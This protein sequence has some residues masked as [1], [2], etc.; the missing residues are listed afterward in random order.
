MWIGAASERNRYYAQYDTVLINGGSLFDGEEGL[1]LS[2]V[3]K[4][5]DAN[6]YW[7]DAGQDGVYN[8]QTDVLLYL[9]GVHALNEGQAGDEFSPVFYSD[10]DGSG[11]FSQDGLLAYYRFDDGGSSVEDFSRKAKNGLL[12]TVTES[13]RFGDH[14]YALMTNHFQWV[15]SGAA[16][17]YGAVAYGADDSDH[18]GMP[19]A[20]EATYNLNPYDNGTGMETATG[21][22]NGPFGP[23]GDPDK[24]GLNNLYEFQAGTNPRAADSNGDGEQDGQEDYDGDN[25]VNRTEQS[26]LSRPDMVDTDDDGLPDNVEQGNRTSPVNPLDPPVSRAMTFGG[27]ATDY[28]NVPQTTAMSLQNW[29][30]EAAVQPADA[31]GGVLLRRVVQQVSAGVEAMNYI[32]ALEP[33]GVGGLRL[34][35]GYV[36]LDGSN[37]LVR[38]GSV[39]VGTSVWTYVAASYNSENAT[40]A[41][42]V[43]GAQVLSTNNLFKSPPQS[44]KGGENFIRIGESY[45]GNL[46]EV[47]LWN[48]ARPE[49]EMQDA[50]GKIQAPDADGLVAYFPF[51]DG[52][53]TTNYF[54][55]GAYH[56]PQ[57]PQNWCFSDDW[58]DQWRH[59]G[60]I[61]GN[62]TFL[63]GGAGIL[64]ALVYMELAAA[65]G[66]PVSY[67]EADRASA[68]WMVDDVSQTWQESG[69]SASLDVGEEYLIRFRSINGWT[70]PD[71]VSLSITNS[72][73]IYL[74]NYYNY[75]GSST[76]GVYCVS[77]QIINE[78]AWTNALPPPGD[79]TMMGQLVIGVWSE[80]SD[81]IGRPFTNQ[82]R[83]SRALCSS[84][85]A[86]VDYGIGPL[87]PLTYPNS[88]QLLA[89]I[90]GDADL[91]YDLGEPCSVI[92]TVGYS[93]LPSGVLGFNL[94][95][96]D[97]SDDDDLPDW[98]EIHCFGDLDETK[99]GDYDK[100]ELTNYE[101][102]T[103]PFTTPAI[104][105]LNAGA[106]DSDGDGMDDKWEYDR[107]NVGFG[108]NPSIPDAWGDPDGDGLFNIQEYN[109]VD[110]EPRLKQNPAAPTGVALEDEYS[111]DDLN[112]S[113]YDTDGD[114]LVDAFEYA[115]Y[116]EA[117]G[118]NPNDASVNIAADP[119]ADGMT[120][121]REQCLLTEF[122]EGGSNDVWSA[123]TNALPKVDAYGV[124]AFVP[125][126]QFVVS[127]V[128]DVAQV[129]E[130]LQLLE[131]WTSPILADSDGDLLPD[132]WEV[133][134]NLNPKVLLGND[135]YWGDPDHDSRINY[136]EFLGQDAA[137]ST[138]KPFI[139]GTGDETNPYQYNWVPASTGPGTGMARPAVPSS[140]WNSNT[141]ASAFATLGGGRPTTS[142]GAHAGADTDD[143]GYADD[144]EIQQEYYN[145]GTVGS[146]PVH[147]MSPFIRRAALITDAAGIALPDPEGA[148]NGYS[149]LLHAAN[150]TIECYVK[151][152]T[153]DATGWLINNPGPNSI[154]EV[155]Y[156]L[157]LTNNVPVLSFETIGGTRY[158]VSGP[159]I[160]TNRWIYLAGVW[161]DADN[162][163]A[164]YVDG[165]FVQDQRIYES[166]RSAYLYGSCTNVTLGASA[167]GSFVNNLMMDE[168]RIWTEFRTAEEIETYRRI[169]VP[170]TNAGLKAYFRFDDGGL[171]AEDFAA[172]AKNTALGADQTNFYYGDMG[173]ALSGG[174]TMTTNDPADVRGVDWRGADDSDGDGMPDAW[175]MI[176]HLDPFSAEGVNGADGD[177]DVDTLRNLYEY[178]SDTNPR[179]ADT[180]GNAVLD[181]SEDRDGDTVVNGIEQQLGSRPDLI[182][183]D[184]DGLTDNE[185]RNQGTNPADPVDP[186]VGRAIRLGGAAADYLDVPAS[187]SQRLLQWTLEAWVNPDSASGGSGRLIR[188]AVQSLGGGVYAENYVMGLRTNSSGVLQLYAG[189]TLLNGNSY[190]VYGGV[191]TNG[192]WTHVAAAYDSATASLELYMNGV[193]VAASNA[194]NNAPPVNGRGGDTFVRIGEDVQGQVDDVRVWSSVRTTNQIS[195]NMNTVIDGA[196]AGL[197]NYFRMDDAQAVTNAAPFGPYHQPYGAQDFTVT[198]DW[199]NQWSHAAMLHGNAAFV[200][201]DSGGPVVIPP[202]VQVNLLPLEAV[203]D[204]AQWSLNGGAWQDST[205]IV[206]ATAGV[207]AVTF[208]TVDGWVTP[209]TLSLTL[210]NSMTLSTNVYYTQG[211]GIQ[212]DLDPAEAVS[213]GATWRVEGGAWQASEAV[214]SNLA[215]GSYYVEY[216]ALANWAAPAAEYV[217]VLEGD[218]TQLVRIY[219]PER[220]AIRVTISPAEAVAAGAHWRVNSN[221]WQNSGATVNLTS[222]TYR[223]DYQVLSGWLTPQSVTVAVSNNVTTVL[224]PVYYRYD[225]I[226]AF[227]YGEGQFNRPGGVTVDRSG[228]LYVSDTGNNRI[229]IRRFDGSWAVLGGPGNGLGRFNQPYGLTVGGDGRLYVADANN[230]RVQCYNTF[231]QSWQAWGGV[232]GSAQG[233]FNSPFDVELDTLGNL[234]VAD[235]SNH[236]IQKKNTANDWSTLISSGFAVGEVRF[237]RGLASDGAGHF[238]VSDYLTA[239]GPTSRVQRIA[240]DGA[241]AS[242][243]ASSSTSNGLIGKVAGLAVGS[244]NTLLMADNLNSRLW[245]VLLSSGTCSETLGEDVL[246]G[247]EDVAVDYQGNIYVADTKNHRILLLYVGQSSSA[248]VQ[249]NQYHYRN[250]FDGDGRA[251]PTV[252]W[253]GGG[254][255]YM[256][257]SGGGTA[258]HMLGGLVDIPACGDYDGDGKT[259]QAV[260]RSR[261]GLWLI[262]LSSGGTLSRSW[263]WAETIPVPADFDGDGRTDVCVYWPAGGM[264]Y[265]LFSQGGS[266][267]RA[268]GWAATRPI[269]GDFDGD[270]RADMTVY[271]SEQGKWY[272]YSSS[273]MSLVM[274]NWGWS[275][276][277]PVPGD[278]DAD[279][280]ADVAVYHP[281]T[282]AWMAYLSSSAAMYSRSWGWSEAVPVP[283][284]YDGDGKTDVAV[285]YGVT[286]AWLI[287]NSGSASMTELNWGWSETNPIY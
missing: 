40:L 8:Q 86:S 153:L 181:I 169:L 239:N 207:N 282:G 99:D 53:A 193:R 231:D 272:I 225:I 36:Q 72:E 167:D 119:D 201:V 258:T 18:D 31:N 110:G 199:L 15:T 247:P 48:Y 101:E 120:T 107:F 21:L 1:L 227:G 108:L 249:T 202:T 111:E 278:Y 235:R 186:V 212:I 3:L 204:G 238:Y 198:K 197:V 149:P 226:G 208:R 84:L 152:S 96:V 105:F 188:R 79:G 242:V 13:Y 206:T 102:Y 200:K 41:I 76:T 132:G 47:R 277:L 287:W 174:F 250:D 103:T 20:W 151:V 221:A 269:A 115:W 17:V 182:D 248:T 37:Y 185:E 283:G 56:Q 45:A 7:I 109:G 146:S 14:G 179:A 11:D 124:Y 42:Y 80:T 51:N 170:Q 93:E 266:A 213:A 57:G 117:A 150:W 43:N 138:N 262:H 134:Y 126:L 254:T 58:N 223:V 50:L 5:T 244:S 230:H 176:N 25:L 285:Y 243:V 155:T 171:T 22:Q 148:A 54:P 190:Y 273:A 237:P 264:W 203:T 192:A 271:W 92:K 252:Y 10:K 60:V 69:D 30:M 26:L 232:M 205:V 121:Y 6:N 131:E 261:D 106:F 55:F 125:P 64:P 59:A 113:H 211:G 276:V 135:G 82:T 209:Q 166:G 144:V 156:R 145:S 33:D 97:D 257:Y 286:G 114:G 158:E 263:G 214:V 118:I 172:K 180:D 63:E 284:D 9:D 191:V 196:T 240:W 220:G 4:Q 256:N 88:Y 23:D 2:N 229:Q 38:G 44:G 70:A 12:G 81:V 130:S 187:T 275:E 141:A 160:P 136:E 104:T 279:G 62:V 98:W 194:L 253:P 65:D 34:A 210:S 133:Q 270:G 143:D 219:Q 35:C 61:H 245:Q 162:N 71:N 215:P 168:V 28:V 236:R 19:D 246:N 222:G 27:A 175:E 128:V 16:V 251:D 255:W 78:S 129:R 142:L 46:D 259:D 140:Y 233:Q 85:P 87:P 224:T 100:D 164:L 178:W 234:Y 123:G 267:A 163:L 112:P 218:I 137:R 265:I 94:T 274:M 159:S 184:D 165:V 122:S 52:Q 24:D 74:T 183:T 90:D 195:A 177:P 95:I 147:S 154:G 139:N 91:A 29:T 49:S 116:N 173:Y 67:W 241:S 281:A 161:N 83:L 189:Y 280:R 268:W 216:S 66:T 228:N 217:T 77:G 68:G 32:L 39:P 75:V 89:W 73:T 127:N 260:F 157:A